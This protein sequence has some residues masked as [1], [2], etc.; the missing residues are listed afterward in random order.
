MRKTTNRWESREGFRSIFDVSPDYIYLTD[1]EGHILEANVA[2]LNRVELSL[3][4]VRQKTFMDFFAGDNAAEV[5]SAF[6]RLTNG[7]E[8]KGLEIRARDARG[9]VFEYEINAVPLR[10]DG[11]VTAILSLA[12]DITARK[13]AEEQLRSS[14][15]QLRALAAHLQSVREEERTRIAYEIH[16]DL[17]QELT[18]LK[19]GLAQLEKQ[20]YDTGNAL[21]PRLLGQLRSLSSLVDT[22]IQSVR[23]IATNL[24]PAVLDTFGLTAAMEWEA[25]EF[26]ARTGIHCLLTS[27]LESAN[28]FTIAGVE[29]RPKVLRRLLDRELITQEEYNQKRAE[30]LKGL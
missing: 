24:R 28:S 4:Q 3:E 19:I 27:T 26:Q 20:L 13:Q 22:T 11:Q 5:L 17:G 23:R 14:H 10:K 12:R 18:A 8:V 15:Q 25:Q 29:E 21:P 2:L 6:A 1:T 30:I 16:D 7:Q 9:N